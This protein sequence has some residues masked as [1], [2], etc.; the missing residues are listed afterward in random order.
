MRATLLKELTGESGHQLMNSLHY[1]NQGKELAFT[2]GDSIP[3]RDQKTTDNQPVEI[4]NDW[5]GIQKG[6]VLKVKAGQPYS[7][8]YTGAIQ[9]TLQSVPGNE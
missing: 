9:W 6:P 7:E 5:Q 4:S 3:I 2:I 1:Y 8:K